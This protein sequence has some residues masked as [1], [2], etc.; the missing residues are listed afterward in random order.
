MNDQLSEHDEELLKKV[1][2]MINKAY[3]ELD[4]KEYNKLLNEIIDITL[5]TVKPRKENH[6]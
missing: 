4:E 2:E 1:Q 3:N 6:E 5:D